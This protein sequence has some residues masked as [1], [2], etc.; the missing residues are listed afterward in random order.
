MAAV[1]VTMQG[2]LTDASSGEV[3]TV[4]FQG[5]AWITGLEVGGGPII[6]PESPPGIWHDPGGYN[7]D[8]PN[9]PWPPEIPEIP[10]DTPPGTVVKP[11]PADGGWGYVHPYGWMYLPKEGEP[12]P[13]RRRK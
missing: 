12:S 9:Q 13:K 11:P 4:L 8:N 1:P 10:P 2:T 5:T 6:P 3:K 7:P